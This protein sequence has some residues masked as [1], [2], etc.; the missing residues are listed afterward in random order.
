MKKRG[1]LSRRER[2]LTDA[3]TIVDSDCDMSSVWGCV[4]SLVGLIAVLFGVIIFF[5]VNVFA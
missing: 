4:W 5:L 1:H 2:A 3:P